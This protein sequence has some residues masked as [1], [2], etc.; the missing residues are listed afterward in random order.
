RALNTLHGVYGVGATLSPLIIGYF[1]ERGL[2]WRWALS[3]MA[4]IWLSYGLIT[5]WFYRAAPAEER[6]RKAQKLDLRMLREGPFLALFLIA[7]AYNGVAWSLLG[8]VA[9]FM[10]QTAGFSAFL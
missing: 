10:Q 1:I 5:Y 8:W 3:G 6:G 4:C 9:I 7:F 2:Q